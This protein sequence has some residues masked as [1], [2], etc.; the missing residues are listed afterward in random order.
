V[1]KARGFFFCERCST[2]QHEIFQ[3]DDILLLMRTIKSQSCCRLQRY[4]P[5]QD[6]T[7]QKD[8]KNE[9]VVVVVVV[10]E[11]EYEIG[12]MMLQERKLTSLEAG[13]IANGS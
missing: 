5:E 12:I 13:D 1:R 3:L 9:Q 6:D 10:P 7:K 2:N 8:N 4:Q 11:H